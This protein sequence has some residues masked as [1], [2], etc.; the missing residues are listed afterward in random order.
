MSK[1][2][3][4]FSFMNFVV[5][6]LTFMCLIHFEFIFICGIRVYS[7]FILLL[8]AVQFPY[9]TYWRDSFLHC[10]F[11][12]PCYRLYDHKCKSYSLDFLPCSIDLYFY[13]FVPIKYSFDDCSF[14]VTLKS[15]RLISPALFFLL[16]IIL[17]TQ[18]LLYLH[19]NF[20]SFCSSSMKNA[21]CNLIEIALN[22]SLSWID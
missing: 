12:L 11:F 13:F 16:K 18:G 8:V 6:G 2:V 15:G 10:I 20:G 5:S 14:I 1:S 7:N 22:C 19:T 3:C 9:S 17:A 4:L 21:I